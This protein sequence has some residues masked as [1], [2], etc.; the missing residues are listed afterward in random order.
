ME[1][2]GSAFYVPLP[3]ICQPSPFLHWIVLL[4][5]NKVRTHTKC[6][7]LLFAFSSYYLQLT[8]T[9]LPFTAKCF[10]NRLFIFFLS[11]LFYILGS[12]QFGF[13]SYHSTEVW[14]VVKMP[15]NVIVQLFIIFNSY[16]NFF[17]ILEEIIN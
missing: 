17:L 2:Y 8:P 4:A 13:C 7:F 5:V 15:S 6:T 16:F 10:E 12:L 14:M 9:L 11:L 1:N 3:S